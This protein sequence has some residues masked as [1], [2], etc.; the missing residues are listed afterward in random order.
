MRL[1][2]IGD[3]PGETGL[4]TLFLGLRCAA[5]VNPPCVYELRGLC[6]LV[7]DFAQRGANVTS[8]GAVPMAP[9]RSGDARTAAGA[10]T[11]ASNC[12]SSG[13]VRV[14]VEATKV[15]AGSS[16]DLVC[17]QPQSVPK[18]VGHDI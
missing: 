10:K 14:S 17:A 5:A 1:V 4:P 7:G 16:P 13:S 2:D 11:F 8:L 15:R 18:S 9:P 6:P 3:L 12:A